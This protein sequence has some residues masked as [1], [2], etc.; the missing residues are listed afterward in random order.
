M[1]VLLFDADN[2]NDL[3]LYIV[4]GG[5]ESAANS[6]NYQ[7]ALFINDGKGN[8]TYLPDA[9]PNTTASG[10]CVIACDYDHDGYMDLFVGGRVSPGRYPLPPESYLL[11]N[12]GQLRF[13]N[14]TAQACPQL[15]QI[16]MVTSALWSD[17]DNDG[18]SDLVLA[19]EFMPFTI[20]RNEHGKFGKPKITEHS[21]G[22]WNSIVAGD[23][24]ND[25]DID[26]VAGNL[27]LN[28]R[29]KA[30][31]KEPLCIYAKDFDKNGLI[32]PLMCYYVDGKNYL[33]PTRDEMI[34]Q[35]ASMRVR[36]S[37]Y[38]DYAQAEFKESFTAD[39]LRDAYIVRSECFESS[40]FQN[41]GHGNFQRKRLPVE[42]QFAPVFGMV[43]GDFNEDGNPDVLMAG[44]SYATEAS[45]GR[46]DAM[47]GLLLAG[48]GKGNF[49]CVKSSAT[50]FNADKDVKGVAEINGGDGGSIILVSNNSEKMQAYAL[51]A[52][53]RLVP[54][55]NF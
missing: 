48:D 16:G 9:L 32:D 28:S 44:N 10:S 6:V 41:D 49:A 15:S 40:Y 36:F 55:E 12:N 39:E 47:S 31:A 1:G 29:H 2:D 46:Y 42:A 37:T 22:W 26:Y 54:V 27:G 23:F 35:I 17:Y 25:G 4:G 13:S 7:D 33:Y 19:G 43:S 52:K 14:V 20:I 38:K 51:N 21:Q 34:R 45:T 53:T 8:F 11:H 3:D 30:S 24:D 50:G 5:S 18:W